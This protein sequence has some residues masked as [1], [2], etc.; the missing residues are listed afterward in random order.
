MLEATAL[1]AALVVVMVTHDPALIL[2]WTVKFWLLAAPVESFWIPNRRRK[3]ALS[4]MW[5]PGPQ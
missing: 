4:P 5:E 3:L 1:T 2:Y